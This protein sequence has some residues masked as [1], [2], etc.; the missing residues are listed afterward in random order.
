MFL[1][2][3]RFTTFYQSINFDAFVKSPKMPFFVIPAKAGIQDNLNGIIK[4]D[5]GS[6]PALRRNFG[7]SS[8][9]RKT[10]IFKR[11]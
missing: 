7:L 2:M 6:S 1:A 11:R 8:L 9:L 5:A 4:L 3:T 10:K